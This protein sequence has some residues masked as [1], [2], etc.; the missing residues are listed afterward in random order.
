MGEDF[1]ALVACDAGILGFVAVLQ[2]NF[3]E[4]ERKTKW[5]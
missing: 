1:V 3:M 4:G 2:I 5:L